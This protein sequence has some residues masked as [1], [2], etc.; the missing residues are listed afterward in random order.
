MKITFSSLDLM[1]RANKTNM[2]TSRIATVALRKSHRCLESPEE[3]TTIQL[4]FLF[5]NADFIYPHDTVYNPDIIYCQT[6][7]LI[8]QRLRRAIARNL[9]IFPVHQINQSKQH[10]VHVNTTM[11]NL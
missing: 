9:W 2:H 11:N 8:H 10:P 5:S 4:L 3:F 7:P 1:N 6:G